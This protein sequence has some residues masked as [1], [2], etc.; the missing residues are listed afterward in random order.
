MMNENEL[1]VLLNTYL[2]HNSQAK[3]YMLRFEEALAR[4]VGVK[5][6]F[7]LSDV[8][9]EYIDLGLA[10]AT[11]V[12]MDTLRAIIETEAQVIRERHDEITY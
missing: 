11:D 3:K 12:D 8:M 9:D 7:E 6:R 4:H 5:N 10:G 1:L 2:K